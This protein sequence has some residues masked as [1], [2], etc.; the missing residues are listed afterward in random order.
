MSKVTIDELVSKYLFEVDPRG[1]NAYED[2][3]KQSGVSAK[4]AAKETEEAQ[5]RAVRV[6]ERAAERA[7]QAAEK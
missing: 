6:E 7:A 4:R 2:Y 3:L 1:F 5:I